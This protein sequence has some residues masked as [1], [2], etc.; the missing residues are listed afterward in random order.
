HQTAL[1]AWRNGRGF[2]L[3]NG[4]TA[5][6]ISSVA[7]VGDTVQITAAASVPAGAIV[8]YAVTNDGTQLPGISRRWGKLIDSD[9]TVGA[10]TNQPQANY[11]VAFE[12]R[13]P[14]DP[15]P[16]DSEPALAERPRVHRA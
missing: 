13:V 6:V 5:L 10:F 11:A 1:T 16:A 8:G 12:L 15:D 7:I 2:E 3:R 4:N 14:C 9:R